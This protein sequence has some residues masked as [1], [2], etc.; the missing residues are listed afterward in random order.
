MISISYGN[1]LEARAE[2]LVNAVNIVGVMGKGIAL[3]FKERFPKNYRLYAAACKVREVRTGQMFVTVVRELGDPHWIVNFP[4][5][6]HWRAPSRMEWIVD[7]LHDLRRLLIEQMVASVAI[8]ALGAG[9]GGLPWAA[10]REQIELALGDLE[11]DIL[12]FAPME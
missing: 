1:L 3:A 11:I 10:V 2:A 5:K 9:N 8:P 12:L 6:Q 7:G 4:T